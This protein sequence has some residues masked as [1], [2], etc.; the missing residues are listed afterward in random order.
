MAQSVA[1]GPGLGV[2]E[3]HGRDRSSQLEYEA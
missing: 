3:S 1:R 2:H